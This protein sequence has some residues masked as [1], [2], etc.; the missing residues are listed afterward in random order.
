MQ[1]SYEMLSAGGKKF[2]AAAMGQFG[3]GWAWLVEDGG[4]L[5]NPMND[6]RLVGK[7]GGG[8]GSSGSGGGKR[9][10]MPRKCSGMVAPS[11]AVSPPR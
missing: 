8:G 1:G 3:S 4:K 7:A 9:S 5:V 2:Q 10:T 6:I 11:R